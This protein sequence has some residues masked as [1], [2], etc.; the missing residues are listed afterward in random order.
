MFFFMNAF[1]CAANAGHSIV[2]RCIKNIIMKNL[3]FI[4]FALAVIAA[5][6]A[7]SQNPIPDADTLENPVQEGDPAVRTLPP[8]LDYV[9]D[10]RRITAE[11]V[12]DPVR[13]SLESSAQ[14][15]DWQRA[16]I[17]H[18]K[19][20]DEYIVEFS[21]EGRSTTY[22]FNKEGKPVIEDK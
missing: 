19:N 21:G 8:R 11:E 14:Y 15:T 7:F 17:H 22:R 16:S 3:I 18:D 12:P 6:P 5:A 9:D 10:K 2:G 13:Q 1:T 20:R 4:A